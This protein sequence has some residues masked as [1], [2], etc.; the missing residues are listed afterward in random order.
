MRQLF[1]S[2]NQRNTPN[3][4]YESY[5]EPGKIAYNE[6]GETKNIPSPFRDDFDDGGP[7]RNPFDSQFNQDSDIFQQVTPDFGVVISSDT[8][9]ARSRLEHSSNLNNPTALDHFSFGFD[10]EDGSFGDDPTIENGP[11]FGKVIICFVHMLLNDYT[12][13]Q[14]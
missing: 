10:A 14:R 4:Y 5:V 2:G 7:L 13:A 11:N 3:K 9:N 8:L 1:L 6:F 12:V